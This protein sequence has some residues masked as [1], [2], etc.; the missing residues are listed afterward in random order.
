VLIGV[1]TLVDLTPGTIF[2]YTFPVAPDGTAVV[3]A[4]IP[5]NPAIVGTTFYVQHFFTWTTC[6]PSPYGVSSS[7][8]LA[9]TIQP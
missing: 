8:A 9:I 1:E 3:P 2:L 5:N 6:S 4:G 7:Q